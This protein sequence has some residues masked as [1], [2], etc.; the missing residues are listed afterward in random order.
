MTDPVI[1]VA[2]KPFRVVA[3]D[4]DWDGNVVLESEGV[5]SLISKG[6]LAEIVDKKD[7]DKLER[8]LNE[9]GR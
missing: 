7:R 2:K 3:E 4:S 6:A 1:H 8:V 5:H 9:A